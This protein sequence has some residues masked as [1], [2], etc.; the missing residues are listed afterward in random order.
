[1]IAVSRSHID[2]L[3]TREILDGATGEQELEEVVRIGR[4]VIQ[5]EA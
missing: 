2:Q 4:S 1:L 5:A 3:L